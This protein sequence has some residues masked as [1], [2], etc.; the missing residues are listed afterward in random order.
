MKKLLALLAL[1]GCTPQQAYIEAD[2]ATHDVI[3]PAHRTY[4]EADAALTMEQ[5]ARIIR[6][7]DSWGLRLREAEK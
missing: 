4:V 1:A 7:L 2:R 3:V 6:L 5:R